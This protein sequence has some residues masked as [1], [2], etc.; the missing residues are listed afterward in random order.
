ME[1]RFYLGIDLDDQYA[2]ISSYELNKKEPETFS[3]IAGSEIYQI[4]ALITKKKGIGQWF[5]GEEAV[6]LAIAQGEE[7]NGRLLSRAV[8]GEK[9]FVDGETYPAEELLTLYLKKLIRLAC[10]PDRRWEPERLV[11]C[12]E[13]L[14]REA[15]E[16]FLSMA[17]KLGIDREKLQLLDRKECFYYFAYHQ[18]PELSMHDVY[19]FD[20]RREDIR[21]C[22]LYKEKRTT[23]QLISLAEEV[24]RMNADS[25][26]E[27]FLGILKDCFRGHIVSSVYLTGDGFDGDWMK[28]SVAFLC[29]GRRAFV[30][31]NLYSK[32]A[33]YAALCSEQQEN[34]DYVYLGDNEMKVNVSLKVRN[35]GKAEFY[36]LISAGDNW[37]ETQGMCEV[38]LAGTPEI[39]FWLQPPGTREAKV[40]KLK[41][42]D[43][44]E[45]PDKA[46]RLRITAKPVSD[47]KVW[48]QIRDLG[49]PA[50][51]HDMYTLTVWLALFDN[52]RGDL[53]TCDTCFCLFF[54]C[55]QFFDHFVRNMNTG[56]VIVH[57]SYHSN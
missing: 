38:I 14:S 48:I 40:E 17:P 32:G 1:H 41:L 51:C 53:N 47:T 42:L 39:D 30:G 31:K 9:V 3:A 10:G 19:L 49:F 20:Y 52:A 8:G 56:N 16:L 35:M 26:D 57:E 46:T 5:V 6:R 7:A 55:F 43:L 45:R 12:M 29:Q 21:C 33:C 22:R 54:V 18:V 27:N 36:T 25:R 15:T 2:V 50:K 24:R 44:P 37:Y 4:P 28:Q 11:I 23:P 13:K 34:W